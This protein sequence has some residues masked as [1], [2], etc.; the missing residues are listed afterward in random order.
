MSHSLAPH[1]PN[2]RNPMSQIRRTSLNTQQNII[3]MEKVNPS[4]K[5]KALKEMLS[6]S[7]IKLYDCVNTDNSVC[8]KSF[9][10]CWGNYQ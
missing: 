9:A 8:Q 2:S 7:I 4:K 3:M 6:W 5:D 1:Y 10:S